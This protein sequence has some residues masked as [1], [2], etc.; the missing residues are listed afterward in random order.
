MYAIISD[1]KKQLKP[2]TSDTLPHIHRS[3]W[4]VKIVQMMIEH[5]PRLFTGFFVH[6]HNNNTC[7][8]YVCGIITIVY[9]FQIDNQ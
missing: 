3:L 5:A 6:T 2:L 9:K 1:S 7:L 4:I 8:L